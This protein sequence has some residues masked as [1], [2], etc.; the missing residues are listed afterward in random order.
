MGIAGE[1]IGR[2]RLERVVT[3]SDKGLAGKAW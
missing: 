1:F 3:L 2:G